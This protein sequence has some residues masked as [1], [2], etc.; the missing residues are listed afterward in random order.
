LFING[1]LVVN[2]PVESLL[3]GGFPEK[4]S[5]LNLEGDGNFGKFV[6]G[7][8]PQGLEYS[9]GGTLYYAAVYQEPMSEAD[10]KRHAALLNCGDDSPPSTGGA[11]GVDCAT[12]GAGGASGGTGGTG[13]AGGG[14]GGA[15][16]ASGGAGGAGG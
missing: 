4:H 9:L 5:R 7:N 2:D 10:I 6:L 15:G 8:R 3:T 13:G 12:G 11:G 14:T 1:D 16:G